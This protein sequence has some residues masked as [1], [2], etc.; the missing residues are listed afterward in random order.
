TEV[1]GSIFLPGAKADHFAYVGDSILGRDVNLGAGTKLANLRLAGDEVCIRVQG[2]VV[3]TGLRKLGAILGDRVQTGC[4]A[5]TNPGTLLGP[6]S[7]VHP[8]AAVGG[9]HPAGSVLRA[10][11]ARM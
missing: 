9:Y 5:V 3:R 6:E 4:N 2:T 1:K 10:G 7:V 8:C 11:R